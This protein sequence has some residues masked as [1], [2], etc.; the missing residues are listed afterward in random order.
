MG[1]RI[2]DSK[3]V[4]VQT[5]PT[6]T[7]SP[8][9]KIGGARGW[10]YAQWLWNLRGFLDLLAGGVGMRRGRRDPE[11][12]RVGDVIDFWRVEAY[13]PD[14]RLLLVAEMK[15]PG[16]A[17]LEFEVLKTRNGSMIR[18]TAIYDPVGLLGLAYWYVLYPFHQLIFAGML[19]AI[20]HQASL[21]IR[22]TPHLIGKVVG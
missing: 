11:K 1:T 8:V 6:N 2:V 4:A 5:S 19:H 20:A 16:R 22:G 13:E 9:R 3:K 10:Y 21:E 18:Q 17:W 14:H 15:L 12:L 7:F